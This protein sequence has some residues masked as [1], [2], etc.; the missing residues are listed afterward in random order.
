MKRSEC[1]YILIVL[2]ISIG[3]LFGASIRRRRPLIALD[4][5]IRSDLLVGDE[6]VNHFAPRSVV[7]NVVVVF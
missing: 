6:V 2:D 7:G 5:G 1:I 3:F 4:S